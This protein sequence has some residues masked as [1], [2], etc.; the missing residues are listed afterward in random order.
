MP[1][2]KKPAPRKPSPADLDDA[3]AAALCALALEL[4]EQEDSDT[5]GDELRDKERDL[6]RQVRRCLARQRDDVLYGALAQAGDEDTGAWQLLRTAIEE[7]A[8]SVQIRREHG[9]PLEVDAFAIPLFVHSQ[10]GLVEAEGFQ[11]DA[12]Y[13]ELLDSMKRAGLESPQS[14]LVLVRHA[15][16]AAEAGRITYSQ[17]HT[18]AQEAAAVLGSKKV[19]EAPALQRSIGG[20]SATAFGADDE[21]VELR[22]LVGFA[23]K[24]ADDPFYAV[25]AQEAEADAWFEAR[26][27]RYR[28]WT[29]QAAPLVQRCLAPAGRTLQL[30]FLYQDLFFGARSQGLAEQSML[31]LMATLAAALADRAAGAPARAV[32]GPADIDGEMV[33]RVQLHDGDALLASA[34]RALEPGSEID[35][36]LDDVRDA[37]ATLGIADV[38]LAVRF[39]GDGRAVDPRP[40]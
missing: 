37:L 22:F 9:A 28:G 35:A 13:D 29:E 38:A 2:N 3:Q 40:L 15:Y 39:D 33:L 24:Q 36:E 32:I 5:L 16:D 1:K 19:T 20:W 26:M 31:A 12:A 14:K 21:A 8:A 6:Q 27:E 34:D 4:A 18:M 25:P 11:D 7:A 23:L 10:G 30:N 17:L